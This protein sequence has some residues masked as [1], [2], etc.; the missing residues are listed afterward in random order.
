MADY[1]D[2]CAQIAELLE[3]AR[4]ELMSLQTKLV[5]CMNQ[6]SHDENRSPNVAHSTGDRN[7][8]NR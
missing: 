5:N 3:S 2:T 8:T 1:P 4:N 6:S 7:S